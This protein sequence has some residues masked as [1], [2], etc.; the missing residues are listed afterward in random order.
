M[1][2][3]DDFQKKLQMQ[4]DVWDAQIAL[5]SAKADQATAGAR[6]GYKSELNVLREKRAAALQA[7]EAL[8][9][10]GEN[11]WED[12]KTGAERTWEDLGTSIE[13]VAARFK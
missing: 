10:R 9:E 13:R 5:W 11:A 8:G 6:L 2:T 1:V 3:K 12:L 7:I 4:L